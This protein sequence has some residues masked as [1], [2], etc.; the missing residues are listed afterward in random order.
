MT[1]VRMKIARYNKGFCR[2]TPEDCKSI[3]NKQQSCLVE[4]PRQLL[5]VIF[6]LNQWDGQVSLMQVNCMLLWLHILI[7]FS[8][9]LALVL[10]FCGKNC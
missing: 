9:L 4:R 5:L 2:M 6:Y 10:V 7:R 1:V 8:I 3:V